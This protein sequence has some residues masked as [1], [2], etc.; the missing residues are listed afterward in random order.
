MTAK[1]MSTAWLLALLLAGV[2]LVLLSQSDR[3]RRPYL[4]LP[5]AP[6]TI[7]GSSL[8]QHAFPVGIATSPEA[9]FVDT[10]YVRFYASSISET[11]T[12]DLLD[13]ALDGSTKLILIEVNAFVFDFNAVHRTQFAKNT[14]PFLSVIEQAQERLA[15][16]RAA[17]R[18]A[19]GLG[20]SSM[21]QEL[22]IAPAPDRTIP[23]TAAQR[24]DRFPLWLHDPREMPRLQALVERAKTKAVAIVL[25]APPRSQTAVAV[26]GVVAQ[27]ELDANID[28]LAAQLGLPVFHSAQDWP[29]QYFNDQAHMNRQGAAR[30]RAELSAWL[31]GRS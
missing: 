17:L 9:G 28:R 10:P 11:K 15:D 6:V 8:M 21:A 20:A 7:I 4:G 13:A 23:V 30:F 18:G 1:A 19:I 27:A 29:D 2:L 25:I 12:L 22:T 5:Q 26:L 3:V 31:R 14:A 16:Y 24:S